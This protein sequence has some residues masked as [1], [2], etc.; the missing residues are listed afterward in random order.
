MGTLVITAAIEGND[1][2][3][4]TTTPVAPLKVT[5]AYFAYRTENRR[6]ATNFDFTFE[7][8]DNGIISQKLYVVVKTESIKD[9]NIKISIHT[10][11]ENVLTNID[12]PIKL[13]YE[14]SEAEAAE[15][16]VGNYSDKVSENHKKKFEDQ[17]IFEV[18]LQPE[19]DED[20][21]KWVQALSESANKRAF[22]YIKVEVMNKS[23]VEYSGSGENNQCFLYDKPF[24][25]A[26]CYC[27]RDFTVEEMIELIYHLRDEE[28]FR[29]FRDSFFNLKAEYISAIRITS[30]KIIE[31]KNKVRLFTNEMNVMFRKFNINTCKRKIHMVAQ[32]YLETEQFRATYEGRTATNVP[33]NYRGGVDFQ[34]RGMKQ[35][36]HNYNYLAYYDYVNNTTYYRIYDRHSTTEECVEA[37]LKRSEVAREAGLTQ[38]FYDK[39]LKPFGKN[40]SENLFHAFNSAGWFSTIYRRQTLTAMDAGLERSNV[41][42]V[43][44]AINGGENDIDKRQ[45]YTR[46]IKEFFKYDTTCIN[47]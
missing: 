25:L 9:K 10:A 46:W 37:L 34:G 35:I 32:M 42:S 29:T 47:K 1:Q 36:T 30:G 3:F 18:T 7:K 2:Q 14:G 22:L 8:I 27:N 23:G 19:N 44:R 4:E 41:R 33:S 16:Q 39:T 40:L 26:A 24:E 15:L 6:S 13:I 45:N 21:Q 43:T 38:D 11:N 12:A 31:N 20:K 5:D 17:T 28:R